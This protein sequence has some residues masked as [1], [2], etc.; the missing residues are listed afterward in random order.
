MTATM[1][2][3][4]ITREKFEQD[5]VRLLCSDLIEPDDRAQLAGLLKSYVF[6]DS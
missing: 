1:K 5:A 4:K 6:A 3:Y 2:R